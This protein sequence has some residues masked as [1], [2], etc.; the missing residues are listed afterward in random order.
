MRKNIREKKQEARR[1]KLSPTEM[2]LEDLL[3]LMMDG[4]RAKSQRRLNPTQL[5]VIG[6]KDFVNLYKGPAGCAKTSTVVAAVIMRALVEPGSKHLLAR[7]DYNDLTDTTM[8]RAQEMIDRLPPGT[9]LDRDKSPPAKWYISP[10]PYKRRDGKWDDRPS[11]ITFMG[12]KEGL[13]SYEFNSA[14]VDEADEISLYAANQILTRMRNRGAFYDDLPPLP[15]LEDPEARNTRGYYNVYL[16]FNPPDTNHWLYTWATGR[17]QKG[18][19]VAEIVGR[20]FEPNPRENIRNLPPTYYEDLTSRLPEDMRKRLVDGEWGAVFPG[21][22]VLRQ[23]QKSKHAS[24]SLEFEPEAS[25]YRFWDFGFRHPCCIWAQAREDGQL[26]ILDEMLGTDVEITRFIRQVK[27]KTAREYHGVPRTIDIGDIAVKQRRDTGNAMGVLLRAGIR[28]MTQ[29][30]TVERGLRLMRM[31]FER[32]SENGP[33]IQIDK[34]KCPILISG[35]AGGYH[36]KD[37]SNEPH[38]DGYYDH[39][40]DA[41]RYGVVGIMEPLQLKGGGDLP[42]SAEY[43]E[44]HD[45]FDGAYDPEDE[46]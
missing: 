17:D 11:Q 29:P 38:K 28:M 16:G 4:D 5:E 7:N 18:K 15:T 10:I 1:E 14:G 26:Y 3:R 31:E 30:Q 9:L 39:L 13:G 12:L 21:Q 24:K 44:E 27:M 32:D 45:N 22:P 20:L 19:K 23:F 37:N 40:V 41:L 35:L 43:T 25:L 42:Q 33:M 46:Q 8:L 2:T 34:A 6:S 36:F